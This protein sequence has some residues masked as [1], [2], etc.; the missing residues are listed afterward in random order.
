MRGRSFYLPFDWLQAAWND[1]HGAVHVNVKRI[2]GS[3]KDARRLS[4]YIVSQY[5]GD[6]NG[7]VRLSQSKPE[8]PLAKM[9]EA[10]RQLARA[11]P[12]RYAFAQAFT[13]LPPEEFDRE[14]RKAVK[15]Q[16]QAAWD[17][18]VRVGSCELFGVQLVWLE[19]HLERV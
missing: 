14:F 13:H 5:C 4:R 8:K 16:C 7:L 17:S 1:I 18:L 10:L 15:R 3:S 19:D 6:Q 11:M 9:R 2:G 12:E